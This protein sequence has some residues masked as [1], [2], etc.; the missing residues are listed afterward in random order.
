MRILL[1][2]VSLLM[3]FI[4]SIGIT[5]VE[6]KAPTLNV[7]ALDTKALDAY[8]TGQMSKHG[9]WGISLAVTS[10]T[11][12]LY[13]KGYGKAGENRPMTPQ[14]PMYIGS[15]SKTFTGLAIAQLIEQGKID[16]DAP[17]QTYIPWFKVED[18]V[19]SERITVHHLLHHTS[20]LSE[21]GFFTVFP[22]DAAKEEVVRAL[23][24]ARLTA[25][26]GVKHQYFNYGYVV[27]TLIIEEVTGQTYEE[28]VKQNI[29]EPLEMTNTYTDPVLARENGLSQGYSRFFGFVVPQQQP[30]RAYEIG[31][32]FIMSTAE[33]LA[34]Y[35]IAM[36]NAGVYQGRQLLSFNG[37][38]MLF[39]A[40]QGYGMGWFVEHGHVF[41]GGANETFKT[42]VDIYP[43]RGM[44]IVLLINQGYMFDHY[45]SAPQ[46]FQGVEAIVL[47]A[48]PPPVSAGWSVRY[49][50]WGLLVFVLGLSIFQVRGLLSLRTWRQRAQ[51]WSPG[52]KSWDIALSFLVPTV[53][54][55]AVFSGIKDYFGYRFNLTYQLINM[56]RMFTDIAILM[57]VGS[58]PDYLQGILKLIW[59]AT[60]KARAKQAST[61]FQQD[62]QL[63]Q[64]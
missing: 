42:F 8:L 12:I 23:A 39:S 64:T 51:Q 62:L 38:E 14:T 15:A 9:I 58:V 4:L 3:L 21:S 31:E 16:A 50:G 57:I 27:L 61:R 48:N 13:L 19:A 43:L 60:G 7:S 29:F 25:P 45:V 37:M 40:V 11:E 18:A 33:D 55:I 56:T 30:H 20:G 47:G 36:D 28:Y 63:R 54:L 53:I 52:K 34:Y 44:S 46:I 5:P 32:G 6:A 1:I 24:S 10:G 26:V 17:V 22:E 49:L 41:H 2:F 59:V 35:T